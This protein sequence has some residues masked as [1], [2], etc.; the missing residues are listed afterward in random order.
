MHFERRDLVDDGQLTSGIT[1][2]VLRANLN[3]GR[4]IEARGTV[5]VGSK[6]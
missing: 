2:L 5:S 6:D 1:R 3:D 4:Q